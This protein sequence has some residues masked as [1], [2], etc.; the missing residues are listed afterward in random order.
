MGLRYSEVRLLSLMQTQIFHSELNC[1][2]DLAWC[3][4]VRPRLALYHYTSVLPDRF[5]RR[6]R[7]ICAV[8]AYF[9][10]TQPRP[11][12]FH[13]SL[14][15]LLSVFSVTYATDSCMHIV[16]RRHRRFLQQLRD[17]MEVELARGARDCRAEGMTV[18]K[19]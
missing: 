6:A 5:W 15:P 18:Q 7:E 13:L 9:Y 12:S 19:T 8:T 1:T 4:P 11:G 3:D 17:T 10:S 2:C 14:S 16:G